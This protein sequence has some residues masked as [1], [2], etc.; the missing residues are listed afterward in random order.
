VADDFVPFSNGVGGLAAAI[1]DGAFGTEFSQILRLKLLVES[2]LIQHP[3]A[4][5]LSNFMPETLAR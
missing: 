3:F 5:D 4:P 1:K 2:V